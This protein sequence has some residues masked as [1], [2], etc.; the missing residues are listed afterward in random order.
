M[1]ERVSVLFLTNHDTKKNDKFN[2]STIKSGHP[3]FIYVKVEGFSSDSVIAGAP[4]YRQLNTEFSQ[5]NPNFFNP[6]SATRVHVL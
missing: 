6:K 2:K 3:D 1:T 5:K 4:F